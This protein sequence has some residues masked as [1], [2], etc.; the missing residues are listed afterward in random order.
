MATNLSVYDRLSRFRWP[1]SYVGKFLLVAF[2]GVHVPLIALVLYVTLSIRDWAAALPFLLV[3]LLATLAGTLATLLILG[4]LLAPLLLTSRAMNDYVRHRARPELPVT[5]SDEAGLLMKAAQES[6]T[7]LDELIRLKNQLLAVL[8]HDT[9]APLSTIMMA[10]ATIRDLMNAGVGD[11]EIFRK[12]I[13]VIQNAADQQLELMNNILLLARV[14]TG[15]IEV[16]R[17]RVL[18]AEIIERV[19][20]NAELQAKQKEVEL[21]VK[22]RTD[23][24]AVSDLDVAKT[25][26]VLNNLVSNALKFTP[27]GGWVEIAATAN[28]RAVEF[29]VRDTGIGMSP[30]VRAKLFTPFTCAHRTGTADEPG[31][32]LG[33]WIAKTFTEVQGGSIELESEAGRGTCFRV[34]LPRYAPPDPQEPPVPA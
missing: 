30:E 34:R 12:M 32:G 33:L 13:N 15:R 14:E 24:D 27:S 31:T 11:P 26:Q 17:K 16:A 7:H 4:K 25:E 21:R 9:R 10:N 6:I 19:A 8:S 5:Y 22:D 20:A 28:S 3:A 29:E 18:P 1:R 2:V 23:R